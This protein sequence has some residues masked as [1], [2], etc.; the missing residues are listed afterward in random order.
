MYRFAAATG[1]AQVRL[2]GSGAIL[3]EVIAA[4][5]LLRDDWQVASEVWSVTSF[6][7]LARDARDVERWNRLHPAA[8]PKAA[9]VAHCLDGSAPIVAA[10]DYVRAWPQLI[11]SYVDAPFVALG[12]DGFGR[13]DTRS[14]LR[15]H[16]EVDRHHIAIAALHALAKSATVS[17]AMVASALER[18][19]IR[20]DDR[21]PWAR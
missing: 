14:A 6:S 21:A 18:Y 15:G 3:R 16:F 17:A 13:S 20:V 5:D 2:L 11:A 9:H 1:A 4:A 8:T 7:E 12:T 19:A 10:T